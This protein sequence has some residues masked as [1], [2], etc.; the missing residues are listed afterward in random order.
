[1]LRI[2]FGT[3]VVLFA[4]ALFS[5]LSV[6]SVRASSQNSTP[7]ASSAPSTLSAGQSP[8]S[9]PRYVGSLA[10]QRCH[11]ATYE[12]WSKTRMANVVRD[13]REHPDAIIPDLSKPDPL[14]TF[15]KDDIA[16]VY[17]SK[18]KQR[19]FKK[20]GNDYFPTGP[21]CDGCHSVNYDTATKTVTEWNVGC[22]KCHGPGGDH[23]QRPSLRN[24]I[25]SARLDY[26]HANDTCIQCTRRG[27]RSKFH[28]TARPT[29]GRWDSGWGSRSR[30][31]GSSK[32]AHPGRQ[33]LRT[34]QTAQPTKI[35]CRGT[36][37]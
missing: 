26:V 8:N 33:R 11:A 34:I 16:F 12:R 9:S 27:N 23:V 25:N 14:V 31:S 6:L 28:P 10:C 2:A 32:R 20:V 4:S 7:S 13:P 37:S 22:E 35:G 3:S 21:L 15:T 29:T 5:V 18:W 30:I 19:Y 17:G 1:M 24:I 36:I